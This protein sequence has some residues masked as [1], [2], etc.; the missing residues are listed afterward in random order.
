M[1]D[2]ITFTLPKREEDQDDEAYAFHASNV[3]SSFLENELKAIQGQENQLEKEINICEQL[4]SFTQLQSPPIAYAILHDS[5]HLPIPISDKAKKIILD[6]YDDEVGVRNPFMQNAT[7]ERNNGQMKPHSDSATKFLMNPKMLLS[8]F[9]QANPEDISRVILTRFKPESSYWINMKEEA[10]RE[11]AKSAVPGFATICA[12]L[13][14][15]NE[16]TQEDIQFLLQA[17]NNP[18]VYSAG[19]QGVLC[20]TNARIRFPA[21][22]I[23]DDEQRKAYT[24][25]SIRAASGYFIN[26]PGLSLTKADF[27]RININGAILNKSTLI[28]NNFQHCKALGARFEKCTLNGTDF[29]HA[30]LTEASFVGSTL[31]NVN[32]STAFLNGADFSGAKLSRVNFSETDFRGVDF[33][34]CDFVE[35]NNIFIKRSAFSMDNIDDTFDALLNKIRKHKFIAQLR[36]AI[37]LDLINYCTACISKNRGFLARDEEALPIDVAIKILQA[38]YK[39]ELFSEHRKLKMAADVVNTVVDIGST[40]AKWTFSKFSQIGLYKPSSGADKEKISSKQIET[41]AQT[42]IRIACEA[43]E[44]RKEQNINQQRAHHVQRGRPNPPNHSPMKINK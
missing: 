36:S 40:A 28:E 25:E 20:S 6:A 44:A 41:T 19:L 34:D 42:D 21:S 38:A 43:L 39:H 30:N 9:E 14:N 11:R 7:L 18:D 13:I 15:E 32:F 1:I 26:C 16:P 5:T 2:R 31:E 33:T 37:T 27:S 29:S 22:F 23:P 4:V 17:L 35:G 8:F 10:M 3:I 12:F 24:I